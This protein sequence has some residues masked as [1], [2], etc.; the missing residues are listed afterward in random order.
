MPEVWHAIHRD[1]D[2]FEQWTQENLMRFNKA[3]CKALHLGP[4]NPH[5]QYKLRDKRL[6]TALSKRTCEY[7]WMATWTGADSVPSQPRKP[8]V[9]WT[10]SK[11]VWPAGRGR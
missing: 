10:A 8:T 11:E 4:C 1:L 9:S 2:R 3:K 6:S 7:W 5:Y